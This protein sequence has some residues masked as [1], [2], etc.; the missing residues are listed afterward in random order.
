MLAGSDDDATRSWFSKFES[1]SLERKRVFARVSFEKNC[2]Q[3][4]VVPNRDANFRACLLRMG[5]S[6]ART[7]SL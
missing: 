5:K 4:Y 6:S 1:V 7:Y 2:S 3:R